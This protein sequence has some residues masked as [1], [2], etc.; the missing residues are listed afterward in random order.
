MNLYIPEISDQIVLEQD[1]TFVLHPESRNK[2]LGLFFGYYFGGYHDSG[3][4]PEAVLPP[5]RDIDY[6][7]IY[8]DREDPQ[9]RSTN[10]FGSIF[11]SGQRVDSDKYNKACREAE[12]SNPEYVKY[13]ADQ[14]TW[15]TKVKAAI[16]PELT[17]TIPK[18]TT[19][20]VDR[21]YIRKGA[22]DYS[23]ITFYAKDLGEIVTKRSAWSSSP[24]KK[25]KKKALRFWA[26]L[27][28]CNNIVF[29]NNK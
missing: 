15:R 16:I 4:I 12:L 3:W 11:G 29:T 2:D 27:S 23:S 28:D 8:P 24:A 6:K 18:G 20:Q 13:N 21:I 9:F 5:M 7:I 22:S 19:L 1:W 25:V 26:K 14:H 17:V 10:G